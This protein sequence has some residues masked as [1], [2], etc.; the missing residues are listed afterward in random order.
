[1]PILL[2]KD[3]VSRARKNKYKLRLLL[4]QQHLLSCEKCQQTVLPFAKNFFI[5]YINIIFFLKIKIIKKKWQSGKNPKN[6][7]KIHVSCTLVA[8]NCVQLST[9]CVATFLPFFNFLPLFAFIS[10]QTVYSKQFV[11]TKN[12]NTFRLHFC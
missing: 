4:H 7:P 3:Y 1:M 12:G 6:S 9:N 2:I 10:Q 5:F 8:T 11:Y